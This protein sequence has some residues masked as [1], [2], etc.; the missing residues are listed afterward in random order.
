MVDTPTC[1]NIEV[2]TELTKS[3]KTSKSARSM[4][5]DRVGENKGVTKR[6]LKTLSGSPLFATSKFKS[7]IIPIFPHLGVRK[8]VLTELKLEEI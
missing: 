8:R 5:I 1:G 7:V 2:V 3:V 6:V 4:N